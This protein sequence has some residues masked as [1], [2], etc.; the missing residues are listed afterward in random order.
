MQQTSPDTA[1]LGSQQ[2]SWASIA[3]ALLGGGSN[4][5][6]TRRKPKQG[7]D[8]GSQASRVCPHCGKAFSS[9]GGLA[10]HVKQKVCRKAAKSPAEDEDKGQAE[11]GKKQVAA[12][13]GDKRKRSSV[14]DAGDV[15][16]TR[17]NKKELA[18]TPVGGK[19]RRTKVKSYA[20]DVDGD[21]SSAYE[22][23]GDSDQED[24]DLDIDDLD[25][26]EVCSE[27]K[28]RTSWRRSKPKIA[29]PDKRRASFRVL[30]P[31]EKFMT[32]FG[33]VKVLADN[34]L[35]PGKEVSERHPPKQVLTRYHAECRRFEVR[36]DRMR[37][38]IAAGGRYRR[39]E[40][41]RLHAD[42][43][44]NEAKK[45]QLSWKLY[46]SSLELDQVLKQGKTY[47]EPITNYVKDDCT[48]TDPWPKD[49]F[50]PDRIVECELVQDKRAIIDVS[51][52]E[53]D[54]AGDRGVAC[55]ERAQKMSNRQKIPMRLYL[56]R[57]ELSQVYREDEANFI[58]ADCG[59]QYV[60][61]QAIT[62][63]VKKK[64]CVVPSYDV[65]KK[66]EHIAGIDKQ[67][68]SKS[69]RSLKALLTKKHFVSK[70][71]LTVKQEVIEIDGDGSASKPASKARSSSKAKSRDLVF[72]NPNNIKQNKLASMPSWIVFD[73]EHSPSECFQLCVSF[74]HTALTPSCSLTRIIKTI[75][76]TLRS[77]TLWAFGAGRRIAN[78]LAKR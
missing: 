30:N 66:E 17:I 23:K 58:C 24:D 47:V 1:A 29:A 48:P 15:N 51:G 62:Y 76:C 41:L 35:P 20:E 70:A 78:T 2:T 50:Y 26:E 71:R 72:G 69:A 13:S 74:S 10:Y 42:G 34:R 75:Q 14:T 33:I 53:M 5:M 12:K 73:A 65:E 39:S 44:M 57:K 22:D 9:A 4:S 28:K 60:S 45:A 27:R 56:Q 36:K 11:N 59:K 8:G 61:R 40:L 55:E 38:E 21:S 46:C 68:Q 37:D 77:I 18:E 54:D 49:E 3:Y 52:V 31:G 6:P 64:I 32:K 63:H 7:G 19:R 16:Q 67:G 43:T 25:P